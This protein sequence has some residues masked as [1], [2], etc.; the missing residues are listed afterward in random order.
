[1]T[2]AEIT[3]KFADTR[4]LLRTRVIRISCKW[5]QFLQSDELADKLVYGHWHKD[6]LKLQWLSSLDDAELEEHLM[7]LLEAEWT[8]IQNQT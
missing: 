5:C 6:H 4:K 8:L 3:H 7:D 1:M 2:Q